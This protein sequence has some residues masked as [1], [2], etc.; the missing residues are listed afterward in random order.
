M[1]DSINPFILQIKGAEYIPIYTPLDSTFLSKQI[2]NTTATTE[3]IKKIEDTLDNEWYGNLISTFALIVTLYIFIKQYKSDAKDR[4]RSTNEN[5]YMTVIIQPHLANINEYYENLMNLFLKKTKF[6][7]RRSFEEQTLEK[8]R[9]IRDLRGVSKDFIDYFVT[10]LQSYDAQLAN[11]VETILNELQDKMSKWIDEY[12]DI[13]AIDCKREIYE[14][15]SELVNALYGCITKE[16]PSWFKK[17]YIE[18]KKH[19]A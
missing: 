7:K 4:R 13:I 14:N 18:L 10:I 2:Q 3:A 19:L 6:L 15:K 16:H 11:N 1:N 12:D 17:I 8:A 5:W 9:A